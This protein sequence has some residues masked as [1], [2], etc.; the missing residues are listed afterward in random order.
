MLLPRQQTANEVFPLYF[1]ISVN[2]PAK[3]I[4]Q[5]N[6]VAEFFADR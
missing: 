4:L 5:Q 1:R 2:G 6:F 3:N